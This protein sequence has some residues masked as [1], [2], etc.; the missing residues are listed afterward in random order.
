MTSIKDVGRNPNRAKDRSDLG[1]YSLEG[2]P[3]LCPHCSGTQFKADKAQLNTAIATLL[4]LD[5]TNQSA[6]ILIC[7][8]CGH[9]QWFVKQP[10]R[11][12]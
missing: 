1:H 5:W 12:T 11:I 7:A 6:A 9:I 8:S 2:K 10:M 4:S 3:V